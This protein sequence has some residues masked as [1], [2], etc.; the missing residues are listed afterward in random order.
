MNFSSLREFFYKVYNICLIVMFIPIAVFLA[1]YY[2][3]L[4]NKVS[5]IVVE[6]NMLN[7]ILVTFPII[8]IFILTIVHLQAG[9]RFSRLMPEPSLGIRL[10]Q[11]FP[12]AFL[13]IAGVVISSTLMALGLF[14]TGNEYFTIY[15]SVLLIWLFF[16]WPTPTRVSKDLKLKGDEQ[17]MVLTKGEAFK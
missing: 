16:I 5:A 6:E 1:A 15:F 8:A 7:T 10:E 13:R 9:K 3:L 14:L 17:K 11:Y 12:I 4:T 2:L